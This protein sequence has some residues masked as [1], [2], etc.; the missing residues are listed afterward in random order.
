MRDVIINMFLQKNIVTPILNKVSVY[1]TE[2]DLDCARNKF[3]NKDFFSTV[4]SLNV[5]VV[6]I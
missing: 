2:G 1:Y 5:K 6:I 4:N 3:S